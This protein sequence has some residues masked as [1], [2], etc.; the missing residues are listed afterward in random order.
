M[1]V[2]QT[3]TWQRLPDVAQVRA[4]ASGSE[5]HVCSQ[6]T[7]VQAAVVHDACKGCS[8]RCDAAQSLH[9]A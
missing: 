7:G 2:L 9:F 3:F 4:G 8:I 1:S 5:L 6:A